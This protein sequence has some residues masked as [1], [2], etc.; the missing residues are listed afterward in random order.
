MMLEHS[1]SPLRTLL[2]LSL[3][4]VSAQAVSAGS[5]PR[6]LFDHLIDANK[7]QIVM[8]AEEGLVDRAMAKRIAGAL[9]DHAKHQSTAGAERDPDYLVLEAALSRA[10]GAEASN[11][12]L[13]RSRNDLGAAMNRMALRDH[14]LQVMT[15]L[16]EARAVVHRLAGEHVDTVVPGFTHAVQAQPTTLAHFLLAFDG[17]LQRDASRLR[18][19]YVRTN[20]SPLG[21]AAITTSGFALNR[22]RLAN[23]LAFD[24]LVENAYDA[25]VVSTAD[26]KVEIASALSISALG[27]G[28][29]A[30][31]LL[32]QY[33][34][35][36]PAVIV[37]EAAAGRSSIM[38]QKRNPSMIEMMRVLASEVVADAHKTT[39][40]AHNT[41]L[42]EV[43]DT[44]KYLF[45]VVRDT[46]R[47]ADTMY[48][49]LS[50]MLESLDFRVETLRERVDK[51][52][53]TMTEL[54]DTLYRESGVPFRRG[55]A[56]ASAL[57]SYG[58]QH[59]K[60]PGE[61]TW[62]EA[63]DLYA[64]VLDDE[65]LPLDE[66]QFRAALDAGEIVRNRKGRGGPQPDETRRMLAAA[67]ADNA[68]NRKWISAQRGSIETRR[69]ELDRLF[70]RLT[71]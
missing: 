45:Y 62:R 2:T 67:E 39:I 21:A 66:A 41:P 9:A 8:L 47:D 25:I 26:S 70:Q 56:F 13:G 22:E 4:F 63:A 61:I 24:G 68:A 10:I 31:D 12:H 18:E 65:Q 49:H 23:L 19:T 29:L 40:Y 11:L 32:F 37:S 59:G 5:E 36:A 17:A 28:R 33:D 50:M 58:R 34:D 69:A 55:Y 51:D 52:Y 64:T 53:S 71:D 30:Q 35:P 6:D 1:H 48:R 14:I 15:S 20:T 38:P 54:A 3:A 57:S 7:A 27:I 16:G 60:R 43:R 44:R 42:H 46:L